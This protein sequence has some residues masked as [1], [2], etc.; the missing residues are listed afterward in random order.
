MRTK[1]FYYTMSGHTKTIAEAIGRAL[2]A[3]AVELSPVKAWP[4]NRVL[5][6]ISAGRQSFA[7]SKPELK[8]YNKSTNYDIIILCAP[9]WAGTFGSPLRTFLAE[10]DLAGKKVALLMTSGGGG[11]TKAIAEFK[12]LQPKA[13]LISTLDLVTKGD[14]SVLSAQ[15]IAWAQ[16]LTSQ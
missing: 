7:K 5:R 11:I 9:I 1:L 4:K 8:S 2:K 3:N 6:F 16:K 12:A 10:N 15:A 13:E 14:M